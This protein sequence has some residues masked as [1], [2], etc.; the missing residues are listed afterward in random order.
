MPNSIK[1]IFC[2]L[3]LTLSIHANS[4]TN[5]AQ[6]QIKQVVEQFKQSIENKDKEAFLALFHPSA[7]SW[8]G[9]ISTE[10]I[11]LLVSKD[12]RYAQQ[13]RIMPGS[14]KEFIEGIIASDVITR[15]ETN[16]LQIVT[17]ANVASVMFEY[18]LFKDDR[19]NN[20]GK[21]NWQLINTP[22]GWKINAVNFSYTMNPT[23]ISGNSAG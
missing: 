12:P 8:V 18:R 16:H 19:L 21:E 23:L 20:W 17:D 1:V 2:S 22:K 5:A 11:N 4:E 10:T 3:L 14:P 9:V 15:E 13:P 7:V 6:Y